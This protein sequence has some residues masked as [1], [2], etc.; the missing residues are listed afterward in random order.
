MSPTASP[1]W[2]RSASPRSN[3][4]VNPFLAQYREGGALPVWELAG[5]ETD[6][7]I[8]YH[9]VPV[10]AD[11]YAKG[12]RG[13]DA[14]AALDA[15][16]AS[17]DRDVRGLP[18][19]REQGFVPSQ[20]EGESVSKTLEYAYDDWCIAQVA[21]AMGRSDV[22]REFDIRAQSWKNLFDPQTGFFRP[23]RN[24]SWI[25]PFDPSEVNFHLTEANSWQYSL[26]VPHD[27]FGLEKL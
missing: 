20:V 2:S 19:Y 8:G 4:W 21:A 3:D 9:A 1:S 11:A 7:M 13:Y 6:C 24:S 17:A 5:N 23:R 14:N 27:V 16:V 15:M 22:A 26:F 12:I 25:E 10:I 18:A